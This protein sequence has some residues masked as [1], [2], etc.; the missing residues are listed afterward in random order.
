MPVLHIYV[1]EEAMTALEKCSKHRDRTVDDLASAAI[2]DMAI[3]DA[4]T[5]EDRPEEKSRA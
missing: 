1:S 3:R 4:A 2:E 5:F